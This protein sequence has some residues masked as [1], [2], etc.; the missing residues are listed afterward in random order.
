MDD[1]MVDNSPSST[2]SAKDGTQAPRK[3]QRSLV[4][5]HTQAQQYSLAHTSPHRQQL[6]RC[7]F[8]HQY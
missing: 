8:R 7:L 4:G 1:S 6:A 5:E 2:G 3:K